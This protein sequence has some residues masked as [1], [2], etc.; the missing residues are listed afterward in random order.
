LGIFD[1]SVLEKAEVLLEIGIALGLG[2]EVI[3]IHKKNSSVPEIAKELGRIEY[4]SFS[5]LI[6]KLMKKMG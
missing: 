5:D 4:E 6:E 1:L 2:K 3:V